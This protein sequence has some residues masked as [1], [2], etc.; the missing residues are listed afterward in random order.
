MQLV[1]DKYDPVIGFQICNSLDPVFVETYLFL[2]SLYK[3]NSCY[4]DLKKNLRNHQELQG[5]GLVRQRLRCATICNWVQQNQYVVQEG[6]N[7][8]GLQ[9]SEGRRSRIQTEDEELTRARFCY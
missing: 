6:R 4:F 2:V 9:R 1:T 7:V 8:V 5:S 3:R